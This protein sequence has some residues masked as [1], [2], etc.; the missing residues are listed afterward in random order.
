M[1]RILLFLAVLATGQLLWAQDSGKQREVGLLFQGFNNFGLTYRS[2]TSS[3]LWR[4][5]LLSTNFGSNTSQSLS[6]EEKTTNFGLG[7]RIGRE[8]RKPIGERIKLRYGLDLS[9]DFDLLNTD[10]DDQS[11]FNSDRERKANSWSA[12][13]NVVVG[14]NYEISDRILLGAE[15]LPRLAYRQYKDELT[16]SASGDSLSKQ[17]TQGINFGFNTSSILLSLVAKF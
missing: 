5:E 13:F 14:L 3:A 9:A 16:D 12:G 1:R 2:G 8:F 6:S 7:F 10:I 17:E 4:Y 15:F 11:L